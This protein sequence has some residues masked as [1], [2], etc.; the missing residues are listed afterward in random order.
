MIRVQRRDELRAHLTA[1]GVGTEIYYPVPL[2]A[3]QCFA[4]LEHSPED[5]PHRSRPRR[6]LLALP[7]YPELTAEQREY[8]VAQIAASIAREVLSADSRARFRIS[9][10]KRFCGSIRLCRIPPVSC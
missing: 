7:I 8:V 4:Y 6:R 3:Q 9:V 2:H 1:N 10:R 5:F